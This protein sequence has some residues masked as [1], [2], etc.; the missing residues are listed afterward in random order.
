MSSEHWK[1]DSHFAV[2][3]RQPN[4]YG[5]QAEGVTRTEMDTMGSSVWAL[6]PLRSALPFLSW[7]HPPGTSYGHL[8]LRTMGTKGCAEGDLIPAPLVTTTFGLLRAPSPFIVYAA[9]VIE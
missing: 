3:K 8:G 9:T 5:A 1:P 7:I 6:E 4:E 2:E